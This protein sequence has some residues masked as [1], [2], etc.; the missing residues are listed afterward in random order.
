[1]PAALPQGR[2]LVCSPEGAW[3]RVA[4][5]HRSSQWEKG[6]LPGGV[7]SAHWAGCSHLEGEG[8]DV[9]G[10]ATT[11]SPTPSSDNASHHWLTS[12]WRRGHASMRRRH[13]LATTRRR[14]N[15]SATPLSS[16]S[17]SVGGATDRASGRAQASLRPMPS[18]ARPT[19]PAQHSPEGAGS[20]Q[21]PPIARSHRSSSRS[22]N[23]RLNASRGAFGGGGGGT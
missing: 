14:G 5:V 17:R 23:V 1:M 22:S 8:P 13:W 15:I 12:A 10:V 19:S 20:T 9:M 21:A 6:T 16:S 3:L 4:R 11:L 7:A 2:G 18:R